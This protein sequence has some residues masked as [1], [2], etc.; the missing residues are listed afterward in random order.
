MGLKLMTPVYRD[1]LFLL[2][3]ATVASSVLWATYVM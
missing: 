2:L 1:P 3:A